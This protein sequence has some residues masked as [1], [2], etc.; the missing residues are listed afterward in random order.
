MRIRAYRDA[1]LAGS[2]GQR[3]TAES[4]MLDGLVRT[5]R[6]AHASLVGANLVRTNGA[7]ENPAN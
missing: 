1:A 3:R 7:A 2:G 6:V 4:F 5:G